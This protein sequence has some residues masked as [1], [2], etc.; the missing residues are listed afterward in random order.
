M[1]G[2]SQVYTTL[3][4]YIRTGMFTITNM[5]TFPKSQSARQGASNPRGSYGSTWQEDCN[6]CNGVTDGAPVGDRPD[7]SF[8][9][10]CGTCLVDAHVRA[11]L[12]AS[13]HKHARKG[14]EGERVEDRTSTPTG[15]HIGSRLASPTAC[16]VPRMVQVCDRPMQAGSVSD[17]RT[18]AFLR[19]TV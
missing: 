11:R 18:R 8:P 14:S 10:L 2:R 4:P 1:T 5:P 15:L 12:H 3:R 9:T 17:G 7:S 13:W 19:Y 16:L 6:R